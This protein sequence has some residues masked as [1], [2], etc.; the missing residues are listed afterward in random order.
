MNQS[1]D[2]GVRSKWCSLIFLVCGVVGDLVILLAGC[3][4]DVC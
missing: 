4:A 3:L 1:V 2:P